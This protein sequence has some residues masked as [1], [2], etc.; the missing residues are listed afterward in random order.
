MRWNHETYNDR[1]KRLAMEHA[2]WK[3]AY[4]EKIAARQQWHP[5]FAWVP[6]YS[7]DG[8]TKMWLET[9]LRRQ[10]GFNHKGRPCWVYRPITL[11]ETDVKPEATISAEN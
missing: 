11:L 1:A 3:I 10:E 8:G 9:I 5:V 2:K 6:H 4:D 7:R